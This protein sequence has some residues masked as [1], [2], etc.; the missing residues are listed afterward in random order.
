[1][2]GPAEEVKKLEDL[3]P[4]VSGAAGQEEE[5]EADANSSFTDSDGEDCDGNVEAS[6]FQRIIATARQKGA[7]RATDLSVVSIQSGG[8]GGDASPAV[9]ST[10]TQGDGQTNLI[11]K[12][13]DE[14]QNLR[15]EHANFKQQ[16]SIDK[17]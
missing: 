7:D 17:C 15:N 1:M 11:K 4:T 16:A 14:V 6:N 2:A 9:P 12:L 8:G 5:E 10:P 3:T 13:L